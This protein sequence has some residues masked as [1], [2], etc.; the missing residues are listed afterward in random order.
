[1]PVES[2][3]FCADFRNA[4]NPAITVFYGLKK[5]FSA[6]N[7][8]FEVEIVSCRPQYFIAT[9]NGIFRCELSVATICRQ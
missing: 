5:Y 2:L 6:K 3:Q 9:L 7:T 1:M 4:I 8:F